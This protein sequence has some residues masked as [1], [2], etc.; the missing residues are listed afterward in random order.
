MS[1][2]ICKKCK[3][4]KQI[5]N[6]SIRVRKNRPK[7]Y[8]ISNICKEC[9]SRWHK[10]Y[11]QKKYTPKP[12][13][14][15]FTENQ[16]LEQ[17]ELILI[18][19]YGKIP[20]TEIQKS[21]L[22]NRSIK[23]IHRKVQSLKLKSRGLKYCYDENSFSEINNYSSYFA[24]LLAAD[25]NITKNEKSF[26]ITLHERDSD[27]IDNFLLFMKSNRPI[28]LYKKIYKV[29]SFSS[30]KIINNLKI[31]YNITPKKSLT[32]QPPSEISELENK[33]CFILGYFDGDGCFSKQG[34]AILL[35]T[36][37]FLSWIGK[38]ILEFDKSIS[39]SLRP[40]RNIFR[41][42]LSINNARKIFTKIY[43]ISPTFGQRKKDKFEKFILSL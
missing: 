1:T 34:H 5:D 6:Y 38:T 41:L 23:S 31:Y 27:I 2:K 32:L 29:I 7:P 12:K 35:G 11:F 33:L 15:I 30:P 21:L 19:N 36:Y 39:F 28:R 43:S 17:E 13:R 10:E 25:G 26:S 18:N 24:G 3:Q 20:T 40:S 42:V 9:D 14:K 8:Y 4:N 37:D 16:Y 22:P